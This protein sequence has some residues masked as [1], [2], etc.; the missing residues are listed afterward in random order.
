M[1]RH[2]GIG[3]IETHRDE[4]VSKLVILVQGR[5]AGRIETVEVVENEPR[6]ERRRVSAFDP[7][8]SRIRGG[9]DFVHPCSHSM[10]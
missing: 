9:T 7:K 3:T 6:C 5:D 2:R 10:I 4:R 8:V 1:S